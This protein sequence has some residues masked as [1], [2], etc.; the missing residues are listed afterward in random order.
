MP[1]FSCSTFTTGARQLVVQDA[2]EMMLC[3]DGVVLVVV[4]AEHDGDVFV[5]G[6]RRDDDLLHAPR[7]VLLGILRLR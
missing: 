3:F 5:L 7:S 4:D 2:L 6:R 1:N